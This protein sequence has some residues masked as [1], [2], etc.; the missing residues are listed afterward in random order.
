[1]FWE[2]YQQSQI[3]LANE[4]ANRANRTAERASEKVGDAIHQLEAK[5]D[6]LALTCQA[7]F[8][9]LQSHGGITEQQLSQKMEEIDMRDGTKDGRITPTNKVCSKC[10]RRASP[11]RGNC[12]YCGGLLEDE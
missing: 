3:N 1:M 12:L 6:G 8:E 7:L 2:F 11:T 4:R 5:V 9:I 10:G